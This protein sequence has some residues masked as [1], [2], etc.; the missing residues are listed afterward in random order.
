MQKSRLSLPPDDFRLHVF[1]SIPQIQK[2][3]AKSDHI[4][5]END[6]RSRPQTCRRLLVSHFFYIHDN[7]RL[8]ASVFT[9][10]I[11]LSLIFFNNPPHIAQT[12]TMI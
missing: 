11:H 7:V 12:N 1:E 5:A 2:Y 8:H 4:F 10:Q 3:F 6:R 9:E